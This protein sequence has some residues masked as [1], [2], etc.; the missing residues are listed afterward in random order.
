VAG[1]D[2]PEARLARHALELADG[3]CAALPAWVT[4]SVN[5]VMTAW[6][7][8]IPPEVAQAADKAAA[9]ALE[10]NGTAI[11]RLLDSDIDDQ[12]TTPLAILRDAVRYPAQ[13]LKDAGVPPVRRDRFSEAVFPD[14]AYGLTPSSLADVDPTLVDLGI[15]WGAAKAFVHKQRHGAGRKT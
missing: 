1:A 12:R 14:D 2:D 10:S 3:I 9:E 15:A 6:A 13:V 5:R 8:E 11:R 7:G 4:G